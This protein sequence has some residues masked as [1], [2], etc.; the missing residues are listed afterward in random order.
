MTYQVP[1]AANGKLS[2]TALQA[3]GN[4]MVIFKTAIKEMSSCHGRSILGMM[5]RSAYKDAVCNSKSIV[6]LEKRNR[7]MP[8][9]F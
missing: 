6:E 1:S 3:P 5:G 2:G 4:P 7:G 9:R 8:C